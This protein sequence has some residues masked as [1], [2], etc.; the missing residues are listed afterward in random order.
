MWADLDFADLVMYVRRAY[1]SERFKVPKSKGS[2]DLFLCILSLPGFFSL[3]ATRRLLGRRPTSFPSIRLKGKK[4]LSPSIMV[5][6]YLRPA[7]VKAGVIREGEKVRFG[8]H[9]F[10]HAPATALVKTAEL[11]SA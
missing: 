2:K 1:V 5:Q 8:F 9:N 6:K 7:A 11:L 3:G 4:P 10:R